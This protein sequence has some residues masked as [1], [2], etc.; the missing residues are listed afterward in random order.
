M[1]HYA[2]FHHY[3]ICCNKVKA[4]LLKSKMASICYHILYSI[5]TFAFPVC[6]LCPILIWCQVSAPYLLP[7][8]IMA[9]YVIYNMAAVSHLEFSTSVLVTFS[10]GRV[11]QNVTMGQI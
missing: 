2:K 5:T 10:T 7:V 3:I 4:I 9:D 8:K 6:N 1:L 11:A